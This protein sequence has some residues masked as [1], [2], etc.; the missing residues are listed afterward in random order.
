MMKMKRVIG[1]T[2]LVRIDYEYLGKRKTIYAKLEMFN[3]SGSIKDRVA[4]YMIEEGIK[5]EK[6]KPGMNIVE[7][8][9]GN[10]G[11]SLAALGALL[12]YPV[13]IFMPKTAS[14]ER[15]KLMKSYG[16]NVLLEDGFESCLEKAKNFAQENQAF[17]PDQFRNHANFLAHYEGTGREIMESL[18]EKIAGFVSG[19]GTGGTL[20][21]IGKSLKEKYP[22]ILIAAVE[23]QNMPLLLKNQKIGPHKIEGIGDEFIPELIEREFIDKIFLISDEEALQMTRRLAKELGLGVG[24]SSGANFLGSVLLGKNLKEPVVTIFADDNKKYLSTDLVKEENLDPQLLA[25]QI[26]FLHIEFLEK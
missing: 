21:G 12:H 11:I 18:S 22:N 15:K 25:N 24:I 10:T 7:A 5:T 13:T 19:V 6:L 8:T 17:Y 2:P 9:S 1:N 16:A 14:E 4:Y 26:Q 20:M 3:F 23:P